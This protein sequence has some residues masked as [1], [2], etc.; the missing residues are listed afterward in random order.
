MCGFVEY[1]VYAKLMS[2]FF[3]EPDIYLS[4]CVLYVMKVSYGKS[5]ATTIVL[6]RKD[7]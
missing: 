7:C 1:N 2:K 4:I 3:I 6:S 5:I